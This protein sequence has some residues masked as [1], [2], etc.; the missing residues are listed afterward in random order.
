MAYIRMESISKKTIALIIIVALII[1]LI[2]GFVGAFIFAKPGPQGIQ[3]EQGSQGDQGPQGTQGPAGPQGYNGSQGIPGVPG[4][5]GSDSVIQIIQSQNLTAMDL[6]DFTLYEWYNMSVI[7]S[8]MS[9]TINIQS[10]SRICA[11]FLTTAAFT[12]SEVWVRIVVDNQYNSAICYVGCFEVPSSPT[13]HLPIQVK[14]L[15]DALS[16]GTHTIDVQFYRFNGSPTLL[17]RSLYVTE[18][19][20]P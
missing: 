14:I 6:A 11:E 15:T 8:S 7:D 17:D 18:L 2:S 9:L 13:L 12:N 16:A 5:N 3:G 19:S 10:L 4:L 20:A 1:G